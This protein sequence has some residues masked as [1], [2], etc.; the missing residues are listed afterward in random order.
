MTTPLSR[1]LAISHQF[2]GHADAPTT[3]CTVPDPSTEHGYCGQPKDAAI[4]APVRAYK[5]LSEDLRKAI[6]DVE[7][8]I[9][10]NQVTDG[11]RNQ[12]ERAEHAERHALVGRLSKIRRALY[13]SKDVIEHLEA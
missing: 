11:P 9:E 5:E 12:N 13:R 10:L 2:V 6:F 1:Q 3:W 7:L 4:H 8:M